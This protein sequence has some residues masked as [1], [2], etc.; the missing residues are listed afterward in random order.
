MKLGLL[1]LAGSAVSSFGIVAY[2]G[3]EATL[4]LRLA[5]W[6]G[7]LAPLAAT[8]CSMVVLDRAYRRDPASLTRVMIGAF[9]TK[10]FFFGGYVVLVVKAGWV[11]P[12]PFAISFVSYFFALHIIEAFRLRR[13][14]TST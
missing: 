4:D 8:L 5:V 12:T 3:D 14:V 11:R 6:L 13:L 1:I 7:M 9:V 2:L 10:V